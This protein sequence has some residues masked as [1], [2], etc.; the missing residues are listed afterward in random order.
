MQEK[1]LLAAQTCLLT[2]KPVVI[3]CGEVNATIGATAAAH[4]IVKRHA[5]E[6]SDGVAFSAR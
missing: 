3:G 4:G 2:P 5:Q 6:N 1:T